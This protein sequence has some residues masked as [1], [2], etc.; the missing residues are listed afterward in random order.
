MSVYKKLQACRAS[1]KASD[2]K[3]QGYNQYSKYDYYTPG[4]VDKLVYDACLSEE[5]FTKFDLIQDEHGL[6][7]Q[8][9]VIDLDDGKEAVWKGATKM[10]VITATNAAQ[11]MGGC[12]TFSERY[13][14]QTAFDIVDNNLDFDSQDHRDK[15]G[16]APQ[17]PQGA[18][19]NKDDKE[20][21]NEGTPAYT[22]AKTKIDAGELSV[23][24]VRKH[25][26]VSKKIAALLEAD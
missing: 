26:K 7:G 19:P 15:P 11:Q 13:L 1:I 6:F 16:K 24:E 18:P 4:Q 14:K 25:F 12:M 21:L 10:P 5:L 17:A 20:W 2:L 22:K 3:K 23:D 9:T 8:L